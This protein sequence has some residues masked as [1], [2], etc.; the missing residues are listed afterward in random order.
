MDEKSINEQYKEIINLLDK[1]NLKDAF[2]A[3]EQYVYGIQ[4]WELRSSLEEIRISY[5]FMLKYMCQGSTDPG[6][7]KL[8]NKLISEAYQ[9]TDRIRILKL[10]PISF[11]FYFERIRYYKLISLRSLPEL[12]MELE[13]YTEEMAISDL[14]VNEDSQETKLASI[15][16]RHEQAYSELFYRAWL[17][18]RWTETDEDE[19]RN[20]LASLLVQ[21]NDLSLFISAVTLSLTE[22][23]DIRKFM[24][25]FDAY[26]HS[27]NEISQRALIGIA[28]ITFIYDERLSIY[29][30]VAARLSLFNEDKI[31]ANDINRIQIQLIRSRET[32]KIDKKMR[33]E[34]IPEMIRNVNMTSR[35]L[36][37]DETDEEN[38]Q[39]DQNPDW[40]NWVERSGVTDKLKE[41]SEL[42]TEGADV[43]MS[44]F[45]QL[46]NYPFF[47]DMANWFYPFDP[48]HS[49]VIQS[50]SV[51]EKKRNLLL[52]NMLQT[53]F[54]CNSDKYSF[55]L[56]IT[57]IPQNQRELMTQQFGAQN[58]ALNM[59]SDSVKMMVDS[60]KA[61]AISNQY[62]QDLYRFFKLHSRR[63]EFKD[64]FEESLNLQYCKTLQDT[65]ADIDNKLTLAGYFFSKGYLL[66]ALMLYQEI[67]KINGGNA[68]IHQR[69]GF[70]YQKNKNYEKAIEAYIQADLQKPDNVWTNHHLA[71]CYRQLRQYDK[72]LSYYRKVEEAQP[73]NLTVLLQIGHCLAELK[74]FEEALAYF[75]KLEYLDS[76]SP[77]AWRAI[78]WCSFVAKKQKQALKYYSKILDRKS[79]MQD[80]L[81]AGH[82]EWAAGNI[83]MA[84]QRYAIALAMSEKPEIFLNLFN[85]DKEVLLGQGI[86]EKDIPL[87]M[88]LIRYQ[89]DD[90]FSNA[91][92]NIAEA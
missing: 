69:I 28:I 90:S 88:D 79:Q 57:Q 77:K 81:N 17:S 82:V 64:I 27:S 11:H 54:F 83:N 37:I 1:R 43:Y 42:Q 24:F 35:K 65:F 10:V 50:F 53:G 13:S 44:T 47:H 48:Q 32:K 71:A 40:E 39:D 84:A 25:L 34:I 30:E 45:S 86:K 60:Q 8:Y 4:E 14:P 2:Q 58:E 49:A 91:G 92:D 74:Q 7:D 36:D 38:A 78:A 80:Y 26:Q 46:K 31:F 51:T 72:A 75:F 52:D 87:M 16:K 66:E 59:S 3:I 68:E 19:A 20:F 9:I 12:Q 6:R 56:T 62:I 70:C 73:D 21:T 63:H 23:F 76:E 55:C 29:P 41:M 85:K 33:E 5:K 22:Y 89:T 67:I 18:G 15:R 61:D